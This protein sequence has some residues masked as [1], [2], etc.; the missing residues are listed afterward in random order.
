MET[1]TKGEY[2]RITAEEAKKQMESNSLAVILDVRTLSL[3][4]I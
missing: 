3:I 4:H 2:N 1:N